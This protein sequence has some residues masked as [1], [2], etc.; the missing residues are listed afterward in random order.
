M[1]SKP[2]WFTRENLERLANAHNT[3]AKDTSTALSAVNETFIEVYTNLESTDGR[4]TELERFPSESVPFVIQSDTTKW[5]LIIN[6]KYHLSGTTGQLLDS[7][8]EVLVCTDDAGHQYTVKYESATDKF[9]KA[10]MWGGIISEGDGLDPQP[11]VLSGFEQFKYC[12]ISVQG[13]AV[14]DRVDIAIDPSSMEDA[15]SCGLCPVTESLSGVFRLF[16]SDNPSSDIPAQYWVTKGKENA[17]SPAYG[18]VNVPG[19]IDP[20]SIGAVP[21]TRT[22]N[23]KALSA[24]ITLSASDIG[25]SPTADG[26]SKAVSA[27][28]LA[29]GWSSG[30]Q[31]LSI[32][33]IKADTNGMIGVAQTITAAQM[34]AA[35][36]ANLYICAQED[37]SI[38]VAAY[39]DTP[40]C[41]IP[42]AV[43]L[44]P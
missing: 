22:I 43:I 12:D 38:T 21:D 20:A 27:T 1:A 19:I 42:V 29:N 18:L 28:L 34:E 6:Y 23:G 36:A 44:I 3:F 11:V 30:K 39:G 26:T 9:Y 8:N 13:L 33:G 10:D 2:L 24:D 37:D 32:P 5:N 17:S 25:L 16:V 35:I 41:D 15:V 31:A 4:V 40:T 14:G 7:N